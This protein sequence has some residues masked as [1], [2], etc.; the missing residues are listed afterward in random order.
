MYFTW[1]GNDT[2]IVMYGNFIKLYFPK[3]RR[4][5]KQHNLQNY[6]T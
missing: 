6:Q 4:L 1:R 3:S 5:E 2:E